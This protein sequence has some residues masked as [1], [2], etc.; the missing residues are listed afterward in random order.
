MENLI[1][2]AINGNELAFDKLIISIEKDLYKIARMRLNYEEDIED[3]VQETIIQVYRNIPKVKQPQYFKTWVV[4][5]LINN[6]NKIYKKNLLEK[7]VQYNE[8][9][10][11]EYKYIQNDERIENIDFYMLIRELKYK[12]R[13]VIILYYLFLF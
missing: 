9:F 13:I 1:L 2:E 8:N 10:V 4:R 11:E 5:I 3:A 7:K 6:C 12:E